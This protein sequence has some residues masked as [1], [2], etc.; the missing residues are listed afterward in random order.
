[1]Q[2]QT[3]VE[4]INAVIDRFQAWAGAQT[5]NKPK[6]GVRELSYEE[7]LK[8]NRYRHTA[9]AG[10]PEL[11][12]KPDPEKPYK[13]RQPM[14]PKA[15]KT[16]KAGPAKA[17]RPERKATNQAAVRRTASKP[18]IEQEQAPRKFRQVLAE[19]L[20]LLPA[21]NRN[22]LAIAPRQASLT[23]RV[24]AAEQAL[25]K[26]RADEANLSVSAYLRQ[27]AF[28]VEQLR[29]QVEQAITTMPQRKASLQPAPA[30]T[31]G[32]LARLTR[33]FFGRKTNPLARRV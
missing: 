2:A 22:S 14:S 26:T 8:T 32:F 3:P 25:I 27:C 11:P 21:K 1:M 6:N 30:S 7:A 17:S 18:S 12:E 31:P 13:E 24:T 28:E 23:V 29:A 4:D 20:A 15:A 9:Y 19:S 5:A 10:L 33:R 16:E